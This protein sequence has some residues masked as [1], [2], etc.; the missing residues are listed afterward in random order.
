MKRVV[1]QGFNHLWAALLCV[2]VA[3]QVSSAQMTATVKS[4]YVNAQLPYHNAVL[5]QNGR[6][7]SWYHP[8]Q[9]MGY[10]H[11]VDMD[12]DF[13]EHK[14]VLDKVDGVKVYLVHP[15]YVYDTG[16][17]KLTMWQHNPPSTFAHLMD[18]FVGYYPY[19]GDAE[20]S[21]VMREMLDY[22]L[23]HG[24][25]PADWEWSGVP[26]PTSCIGDKEY[27]HCLQDTPRDFY[28][29]IET[30][31]IGELGLSYTQFYEFTGDRKY[32]EAGIRCA[33]QLAKHIR[34][35]DA[36]HTPWPF[37]I[38]A[39]TGRVIDGEEY[40]G[41]IVAPV[42]LFTEL[43][44]LH[45]GNVTEYAKA[46]TTAWNWIVENPLNKESAAWDKWSGYYED[47]PKDTVNENDMDSMLV[48]YYILSQDDPAQVDPHWKIHVR[49]LIERSRLLLGRGPFF[50]AWGIDEQLRPDGLP[51]GVPDQSPLKPVTGALLGT[52]NRGCCS[53]VGI[54]CRTSQWGAI[55]AMFYQKTGDGQALEDAFRSLNYATYFQRTNG[56]I[57]CCGVDFDEYWFEDG[58]SDA[59]RSF[60][61]AL[62]AVPSF[63]PMGQNHLLRS[64][65]IV[66]SVTYG[67][68][69]VDYT[70]FDSSGT[71]VFRLNFKPVDVKAGSASLKERNDLI[72]D[73]Y[74]IKDLGGGDFEIDLRRS[75]A[76]TITLKG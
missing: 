48:A 11:F 35:G 54:V 7:L 66:K 56:A 53:S 30:D 57:T 42:R 15:V 43:E 65:S 33:D 31:K 55:N 39:R 4:Y 25:T 3:G 41:M 10:D 44:K 22:Q 9:N 62:A 8:E 72:Q 74:T 27:G 34:P 46:R 20:A 69:S 45:E 61:W 73:G 50:G 17:G 36:W 58:H 32:L 38:D 59:G 12:W 51:P 2:C 21:G 40:G 49:H 18:M 1:K 60:I 68:R 28:G 13:L 23:V 26:L 37:R 16:Q 71:E 47:V 24:T 52:D 19:S 14:V 5:D 29:G 63:A 67:K 70:T 76:T 64:S 75:G 6:L